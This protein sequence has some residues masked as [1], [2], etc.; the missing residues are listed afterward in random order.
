MFLNSSNFT[1]KHLC[2]SLF[3][4]KLQACLKACNFIKTTLQLKCFPVKFAKFLRTPFL[5]ITSGGWICIFHSWNNFEYGF[6]RKIQDLCSSVCLSPIEIFTDSVT[7]RTFSKI[8][9]SNNFISYSSFCVNIFFKY[10]LLFVP[11]FGHVTV[12]NVEIEFL[13]F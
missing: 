3:L 5:Q 10:L 4:I 9:L 2:W 8:F 6:W 12:K 7:C 13:K 1:G 11:V